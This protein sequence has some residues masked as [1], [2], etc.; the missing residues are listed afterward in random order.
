M[1]EA[2]VATVLAM[3]VVMVGYQ[4]LEYNYRT[5]LM[6]M[7]TAAVHST[8]RAIVELLGTDVEAAG[9]SPQGIT[10]D[11]IPSGGDTDIRMLAD[12]DGDGEV[13]TT[14][15]ELDENISYIFEESAE[16]GV[17]TLQRGIDLNGDGDFDDDDEQ[18][19]DLA[20]NVVAIDYDGDG[21][22]E[23]FLA[24]DEPPPDSRRVTLTFG[25]RQPRR[26]MFREQ[27][28]V[29]FQADFRLR[30]VLD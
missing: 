2:L 22:D 19:Y 6:Q 5:Y 24:Y 12:L 30:N 8:G 15:D 26:M 10:F 25:L 14:A 9:Y 20:G 23:D 29:A 16:A 13:G 4:F 11:P 7:D 21:T 27:R 3:I 18:I 28:P 1:V 17:W